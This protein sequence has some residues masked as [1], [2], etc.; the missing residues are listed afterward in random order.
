MHAFAAAA[1]RLNRHRLDP[2]PDASIAVR[3]ASTVV[4]NASIVERNAS[5]VERNRIDRRA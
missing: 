4:R 5:I 3:S 1:S 2:G